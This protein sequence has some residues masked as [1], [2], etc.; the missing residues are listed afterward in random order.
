M[1]PLRKTE[2]TQ[3]MNDELKGRKL[4]KCPYCRELLM[5][6]HRDDKVELFTLPTRKPVRWQEVKQCAACNGS[7]G[8][9]LIKAEDGL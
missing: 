3:K 9:N 2:S 4:I 1:Q 6:L 5:D 8:Y 7:V